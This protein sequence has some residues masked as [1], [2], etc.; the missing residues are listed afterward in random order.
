MEVAYGAKKSLHIEEFVSNPL[1]NPL[2]RLPPSDSPGVTDI[3]EVKQILVSMPGMSAMTRLLIL[4]SDER[5][6]G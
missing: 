1:L 2:F 4:S 3:L 6:D 5:A